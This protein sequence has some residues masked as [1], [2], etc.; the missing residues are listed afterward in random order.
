MVKLKELQKTLR[1]PE[2][3]T[4]SKVYIEDEKLY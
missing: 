2:I 3:K 4:H 1:L